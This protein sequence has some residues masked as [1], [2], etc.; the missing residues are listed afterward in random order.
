[1]PVHEA[2]DIL[3]MFASKDGAVAVNLPTGWTNIQDGLTAG[4]AY[5]VAWRLAASAVETLTVTT[6]TAE[7]WTVCVVSVDECDTVNPII[8]SAESAADDTTIPFVG[9]AGATISP[10]VDA[11]VF[12]SWFSDTGLGPTAYPP[13]VNLYNGDSGAN[14]TG[15]AYTVQRASAALSACSWFGGAN[16]DGRGVVFALRNQTNPTQIEAYSDPVESVAT[17]VRALTSATTESDTYPTSLTPSL[18]G[19]DFDSVQRDAGSVF[20]D[21]TTEA[22]NSTAADVTFTTGVGNAL[23]FGHA[24]TFRSI[25][26]LL[27]TAG[28]GGTVVWEY[29]NGS[30]WATLSGA[31]GNYT[32]TN[33]RVAFDAPTDWATTTVNGVS[34]LFWVR[35]RITVTFTTTP[36]ITQVRR[37]GVNLS[38]DAVTASADAGTNPYLNASRA[39]PV[40]SPTTISGFQLN[41][42]AAVDLDTG[43][44]LGTYR[45]VLPRDCAI[46]MG[47]RTA[48]DIGA[49]LAINLIDASDNYET[50]AISARSAL[51]MD[52]N[53]RNVYAIDWNGAAQ[54]VAIRG[55]INKSA[56]NRVQFLVVSAAGQAD[57]DFSMFVIVTKMCIAGGTLTNPLTFQQYINAL[58]RSCGY[59]PFGVISG[60]AVTI[61]CPIQVGGGNNVALSFNLNTIQFPRRWNGINYF[62]WNAGD[63]VSGII[64]KG[65][66]GDVIRMT[67]CVFTSG[68]KYRW[69]FDAAASASATYDFTGST[70]V[71]ATVTLRAV[72]TFDNMAFINCTTFTQN[73]AAISN[74]SFTNCTITCNNPSN[75]S[76][77][78]FTSGGTG[79][80]LVLTTPGTYTFDGNVFSGYG[81][82]GT[83][84]AAIY[85]D[86]GGAV[87][88]NIVG[89]GGTPTVRNGTG[90]STTINANVSITL[91]NLKNPSEVRV[92]DA[93]TQTERAG[94]G[95]E[96]VTTGSHT[97][98]IPSGTAVDI[99]V[100]ALNYQNLRILNYSTT[101]DASIPVSQV[102]DRQYANP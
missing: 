88:L 93:G 102:I 34:G 21:L 45:G 42:G 20:T 62:A 33:Q 76:D 52:I 90:A 28:A 14:S 38:F 81:A 2:N 98:S 6:G 49:G 12:H 57:I 31:T 73:S 16:D 27:S 17:M 84:N 55:T 85:N 43:I 23:Y 97:F 83:T 66:A 41:F 56:V 25:V 69:E 53:G 63:N 10:E 64:F 86:S 78:L 68:S 58:N 36:V 9:P 65:K 5:R 80:A 50:Y 70:V 26:F 22:N 13:F 46:D 96:N 101:S 37:N 30:A 39:T 35:S 74:S 89:G 75:I 48:N 19:R 15:V 44:I 61:W 8:V 59:F 67:N 91:T 3:L 4:A 18:V 71:N 51:D 79:H 54:E 95:N 77:C 7:N 40:A 24:T 99:V 87:T 72:Y 11:L 60:D 1:M 29:W 92:F 100:L 47:F 32:A 82:D 94:T